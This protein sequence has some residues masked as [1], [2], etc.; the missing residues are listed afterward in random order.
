MI[1]IDSGAT[2]CFMSEDIILEKQIPMNPHLQFQVMLGNGK[3]TP[4]RGI[5]CD[6]PFSIQGID[7]KHDF[8]PYPLQGTDVILGMSWLTSLGW[9]NIHWERLLI[10]FKQGNRKITLQGNQRLSCGDLSNK[11]MKKT[12]ADNQLLLIEL[13]QMETTTE[14]MDFSSPRNGRMKCSNHF[15][16]YLHL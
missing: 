9:T 16:Q 12:L 8:L 6:V 2:H 11:E 1:L 7:L 3:T 4:G 10:S 13:H 14:D 15:Q 5:C